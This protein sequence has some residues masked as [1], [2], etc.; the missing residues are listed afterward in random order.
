MK[1][2][3]LKIF[4]LVIVVCGFGIFFCVYAQKTSILTLA[5]RYSSALK[6]IEKQKTKGSIEA[7]YRRGRILADNLDELEN[8]SEANYALVEKKM[9][10]FVINRSAVIYVKPDVNYFKKLS[11]RLGTKSDI[12]FFILLG[13]LRPE[14][15]GLN[16]IEQQTD[17]SGCT[18][19][20][21]GILTGLYGKAKRFR[22]QYSSVYIEDIKEEIGDIK[23]NFTNGT[24]ACGDSSGV[25][26]E[27]QL[28]IKT[29][30]KD[31]ITPV[32][33]KRLGEV[34]NKKTAIRFNCI[35]G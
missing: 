35:S 29:F 33:R 1:K 7:V 2:Q 11:K 30:P 15:I 8:L 5:D 19:Y 27:F 12:A 23:S 3:I 17:Y 28:F 20:G 21:K 24:C 9:K 22:R 31:E 16:Y 6:K 10:G 34:Q 4:G 25:I 32:V 14:S 18:I 26:K 13:E